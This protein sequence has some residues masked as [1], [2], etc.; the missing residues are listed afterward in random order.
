[1]PHKDTAN[2]TYRSKKSDKRKDK[3]KRYG[4]YSN[5]AIRIK[6]SQFQTKVATE[7]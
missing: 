7:H 4:K 6:A 2:Q 3:W 1:M 5:R